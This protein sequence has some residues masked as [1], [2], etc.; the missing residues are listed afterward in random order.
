MRRETN[1]EEEEEEEE[2]MPKGPK[3]QKGNRVRYSGFPALLRHS[4]FYNWN[5]VP[6]LELLVKRC[7]T[8]DRYIGAKKMELDQVADAKA[9]FRSNSDEFW[10]P[11]IRMIVRRVEMQLI[12]DINELNAERDIVHN[13]SQELPKYYETIRARA[14]E[15]AASYY[16][17]QQQQQRQ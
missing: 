9:K 1:E 11:T 2:E 4:E 10:T 6:S 7:N 16:E 8:L 17:Q 5:P 3:M 15:D 12:H 13:A 14:K